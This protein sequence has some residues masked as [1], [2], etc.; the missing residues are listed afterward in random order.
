MSTH[1][2]IKNGVFM[3]NIAQKKSAFFRNVTSINA[4]LKTY[5]FLYQGE[6]YLSIGMGHS[7]ISQKSSQQSSLPSPVCDE[8][9]KR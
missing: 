1:F 9:G 3:G 6:D 4:L 8:K 7:K 2:A 5:H